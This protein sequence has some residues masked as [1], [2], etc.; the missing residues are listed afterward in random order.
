MGHLQ[1]LQDEQRPWVLEYSGFLQKVRRRFITKADAELWARQVG[2]FRW[3]RLGWATLTE[4]KGGGFA[5]PSQPKNGQMGACNVELTITINLDNAA[6]TEGGADEVGRILASI[7]ERVPDPL[8][9]TGGAL[10]LHDA[11]GN[12]VGE[13][14]ITDDAREK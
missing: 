9:Q 14:E 10:S 1:D 2:V 7:A 12:Y 4:E 8:D 6:F 13:A 5:R 3:I 11:N